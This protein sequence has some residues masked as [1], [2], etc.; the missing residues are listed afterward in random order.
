MTRDK[1][2]KELIL[3]VQE[4]YSEKYFMYAIPGFL[5]RNFIAYCAMKQDLDILLQY[6]E[7]LTFKG[8][9]TILKSSLTYGIITLYGKCYTDASH[10]KSAK[11]E[12]KDLF[13]EQP[14]HLKTHN[15]LMKMRHH[16]IAHRGDTENEIAISF[17]LMDKNPEGEQNQIRFKRYK[18]AT[19]PV[20]TL[21]EIKELVLFIIECLI[22]K[23]QKSGDRLHKAL[24]DIFTPEQINLM[25]INNAK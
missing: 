23:I 10:Y 18:Q 5:S 4:E 25:L 3:N 11:L 24:L 13:K 19:F 9:S 21:L 20:Q 17:M 16:F 7:E 1:R 2:L 12:A 15:E 8:H 22:P 14:K 6:I